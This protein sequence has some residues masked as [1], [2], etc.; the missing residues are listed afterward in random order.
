MRTHDHIRFCS[1]LPRQKRLL[2]ASAILGPIF[3]DC[4]QLVLG[5]E[6][7][8]LEAVDDVLEVQDGD[9][10]D[11]VLA[12]QLADSAALGV[13]QCL[14]AV[15]GDDDA[16]DDATLGADLVDGLALGGAGGDDV[17]DDEDAAALERGADD[18]SALT[19]VLGLLAVE[20]VLDGAVA[21]RVEL[22]KGQGGSCGERDS[23]VG[24]T[25]DN[26]ELQ[27]GCG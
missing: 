21:G 20:R 15:E 2:I 23:L 12:T 3:L 1:R 22:R 26:V 9:D 25:E 27:V 8:R 24:R 6:G 13:G 16:G 17:V 19:V 4:L 5:G 10:G 14:L 11:V 7:A 18:G